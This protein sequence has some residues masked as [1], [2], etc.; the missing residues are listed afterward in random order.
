MYE[1]A[2][3]RERKFFSFSSNLFL[4]GEWCWTLIDP[5]S[6]LN[7]PF[8]PLTWDML[9]NPSCDFFYKYL[10]F[11]FKISLNSHCLMRY[12][13]HKILRLVRRRG[14]LRKKW[15]PSGGGRVTALDIILHCQ[16]SLT[17]ICRHMTY[18]LTSFDRILPIHHHL[19]Y[20][21]SRNWSH[22]L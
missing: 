1:L 19:Y 13:V 9:D 20:T 17:S 16:R 21:I 14:R 8:Y 3:I 12:S 11:I 2:E 6:S 4:W 10:F 22:H 5:R 18:R 15:N 7:P